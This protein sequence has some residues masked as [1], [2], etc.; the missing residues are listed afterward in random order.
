M[1]LDPLDETR[2]Y[3]IVRP[4]VEWVLVVFGL[5]LALAVVVWAVLFA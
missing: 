3:P 1:P 2:A 4:W 5:F